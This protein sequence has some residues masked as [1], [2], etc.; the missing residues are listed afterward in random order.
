MIFR[1]FT[2][3]ISL[4]SNRLSRFIKFHYRFGSIIKKTSHLLIC[5]FAFQ[6]SSAAQ[7]SS[8][9]RVSLLTCTPGDELYSIF[10][11][12]AIRIIDSSSVTDIVYNY[13]TFNFDD[14]GF[15]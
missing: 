13:G 1:A 14:E 11:H 6:F 8:H 7:D 2:I 5:L 10:G 15:I 4:F 9:L 12:S 3:H